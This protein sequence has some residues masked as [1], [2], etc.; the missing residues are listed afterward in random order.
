MTFHIIRP[1]RNTTI[2]RVWKFFS[3]HHGNSRFN[4]GSVIVHNIFAYFTLSLSAAQVYMIKE[5]CWFSKN[6]LLYWLLFPH[7]INVLFLSSQF[8]VIHITDENNPFS[9]CTKKHSQLETFS[10]PCC[11][12]IFSNCLSHNTPARRWPYRF[13]SRGTTGSSILDHDLGHLCRGRRI[14]MSGHSDFGIF[15][16]FR[17]SSTYTWV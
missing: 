8:D 9:R 1:W 13:R 11:N 2:L 6:R 14:Q 5:R 7:R 12:R 4:H 17:A 15:N 3:S 16:D 10:Q